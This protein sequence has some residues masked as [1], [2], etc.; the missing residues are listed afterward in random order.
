[1]MPEGFGQKKEK[2]LENENEIPPEDSG[3][4]I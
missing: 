1:M 2:K 3:K 4:K